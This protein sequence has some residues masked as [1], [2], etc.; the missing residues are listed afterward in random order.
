MQQV[1]I[2]MTIE[3]TLENQVLEK[4]K[5]LPKVIETHMLYGP[6]DVYLKAEA[7]TT[8]ELERLVINDIRNIKGIRSTMTCF[9]AD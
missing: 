8:A 2:L 1:L 7:K 6:Y 9:I 3:P 5:K 4:L